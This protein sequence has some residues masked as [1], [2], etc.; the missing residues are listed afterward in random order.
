[1]VSEEKKTNVLFLI[2]FFHSLSFYLSFIL[3]NIYCGMPCFHISWPELGNMSKLF[4][5]IRLEIVK[6]CVLVALTMGPIFGHKMGLEKSL[7]NLSI[8]HKND[9]CEGEDL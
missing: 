6:N 7:T 4:G 3:T 1:M 5:K 8:L 2:F 9:D